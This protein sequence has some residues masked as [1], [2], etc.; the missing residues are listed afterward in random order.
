MAIARR[1]ALYPESTLTGEKGVGM[2]VFFHFVGVFFFFFFLVVVG[3]GVDGVVG[4]GGGGPGGRSNYCTN[5]LKLHLF[6]PKIVDDFPSH[7]TKVFVVAKPVL[8]LVM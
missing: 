3:V 2:V 8:M 6:F 5:R 1:W 7:G 4:G